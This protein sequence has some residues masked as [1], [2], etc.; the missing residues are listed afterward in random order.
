[1]KNKTFRIS[2]LSSAKC[3]QLQRIF[4]HKKKSQ[5][6]VNK[7]KIHPR[8]KK[9]IMKKCNKNITNQG[10][11]DGSTQI[12][13]KFFMVSRIC[14]V[15][16]N[17]KLFFKCSWEFLPLLSVNN[18][19]F[20]LLILHFCGTFSRWGLLWIIFGRGEMV[21][22]CW[23]GWIRWKFWW[24]YEFLLVLKLVNLCYSFEK[25]CKKSLLFI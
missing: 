18:E 25:N 20:N 16:V 5:H 24:C 2:F 1:M 11:L 21:N 8:Q 9:M 19:L 15:I 17:K 12:K 23:L 6:I 13:S 10:T 4:F 3:M 22:L 7:N 14:D